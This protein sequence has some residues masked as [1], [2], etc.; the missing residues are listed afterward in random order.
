MS[1]TF[2]RVGVG[3]VSVIRVPG[4]V[5]L[6][7]KERAHA[8]SHRRYTCR[9]PSLLIRPGSSLLLILITEAVGTWL[10]RFGL[11]IEINGLFPQQLRN[12]LEGGF[13]LAS[14]KQG[15]VTVTDDGIRRILVDG[16]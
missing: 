14:Q 9:R 16:L 15:A 5:V 10:R 8:R 12:F 13:L 1:K 11:V 7:R 6:V 2:F 3:R 4:E